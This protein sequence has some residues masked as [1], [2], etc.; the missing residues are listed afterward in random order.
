MFLR[1]CMDFR[2]NVPGPWCGRV[3]YGEGA[4]LDVK[5][6]RKLM[7]GQCDAQLMPINLNCM[8]RPSIALA[9]VGMQRCLPF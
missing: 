5:C 8:R 2:T 4:P 6:A 1:G 7:V 3:E 9:P